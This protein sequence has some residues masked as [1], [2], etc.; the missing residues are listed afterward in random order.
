MKKSSKIRFAK[1]DEFDLE[2]ESRM[3]MFGPSVFKDPQEPI[4]RFMECN[5]ST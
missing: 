5:K 2:F 3:T 1:F 4:V